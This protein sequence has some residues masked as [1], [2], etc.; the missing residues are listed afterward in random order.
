MLNLADYNSFFDLFAV[1]LKTFTYLYLKLLCFIGILT[2]FKILI[3][4]VQ[5]FEKFSFIHGIV[6]VY[7]AAQVFELQKSIE[8]LSKKQTW[9]WFYQNF[10]IRQLQTVSN[11]W[12]AKGPKSEMTST[13]VCT[14]LK[15][16]G[17]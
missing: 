12:A 11:R 2:V 14:V 17:L 4:E 7:F 13:F 15:I 8:L 9:S 3:S 10:V 5:D 1:Y 16:T 6:F